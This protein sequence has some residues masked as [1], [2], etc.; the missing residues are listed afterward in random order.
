MLL[1]TQRR[2]L[3]SLLVLAALMASATALAFGRRVLRPSSAR[4]AAAVRGGALHASTLSNPLLKQDGLPQF[5]EIKPDQ[6]K[7]AVTEILEKLGTDL[8]ALE[9]SISANPKPQYEDVVEALEKVEAPIEYAWGVV[10][11]LTGVMNSDE[12]REVHQ[13]MQGEVVKVTTKISQSAE[14]Y[15]AVT[16][17]PKDTLDEAQQRIVSSSIKGM[18]LSG[19]GLEGAKK[20][21]FNANRIR[22]SE[23]S[24]TFSNNVLDATKAFELIVNDK[25]EMEGLPPSAMALCAQM[26]AAAGHEA[27]TAEEGPWK[28]GLDMPSYLPAMQHLKSSAIR[29]KLYRAFVTRAGTENE[30]LIAEILRL[31]KEQASILGFQS[32]AEVSIE[33]KMAESVAEVDGLT[34]ELRAK[35]L[36]AAE[37]ELATLTAYAKKNG[38]EGE[39]LE[40]WDTTFWSERQSEEL[41]GFEEEELRPYFALPNVLNGLFGLCK[42]I[43]GV[44]IVA[45]DGEAPVWHEDVRFFKVL[46]E[47][48]GEHISSFYLDPYSR[49]ETKRGGAWMDVCVGRSKVSVTPSAPPPPLFAGRAGAPAAAPRPSFLTRRPNRSNF[50]RARMGTPPQVLNRK[51]VAYLTCNGSP[52]VGDKPSLM[53]F[54]EVTTLFHETGHGLQH[55][56]TQVPHAPAAGI[57][58]VEWDAVELPSQFMEVI[59]ALFPPKQKRCA[60]HRFRPAARTSAPTDARILIRT[61]LR[62][63]ACCFPSRGAELVLRREDSIR[64]WSRGAL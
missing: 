44:D 13:E 17:V 58:G 56:L 47:V 28:L 64:R 18:K 30:P 9:T 32:H 11:H 2:L 4:L 16:A 10:G 8:S 15:N 36:P 41:F 31:R 51:P 60:V 38:F 14:L 3:G 40:L 7:P 24:T 50:P 1:H 6:V 54:S 52:P 5:D 43:F 33:R 27:A 45:A 48:S 39:K 21:T 46:D 29:E 34:E 12:L 59:S 25:A 57:S 35:A 20:E 26:A 22:L 55:M 23:L 37:K 49:P 19:V 63:R 61:L 53:T 62:Y 42:R